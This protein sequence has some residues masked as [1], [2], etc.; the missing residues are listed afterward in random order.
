[1]LNRLTHSSS[2]ARYGAATMLDGS[3]M[4]MTII[5]TT[6]RERGASG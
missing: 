6:T 2:G 5:I 1:M 3:M 4:F